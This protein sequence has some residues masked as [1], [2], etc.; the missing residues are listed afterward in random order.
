MFE[1]YTE[2]ARRVIFFSRYEASQYGSPYIEVAH[3]LLGLVREDFPTVS[4]V[5]AVEKAALQR[6]IEGLCVN[7]GQRVATTVDLPLAHPCRRVLSYAAEESGRLG[8]QHIGPEHLIMG[9][10]LE[11]GKEADVL[12][13]LGIGLDRAREV[14]RAPAA[15]ESAAKSE[16]VSHRQALARLLIQVPEDRLEAAVRILGCLSSGYFSASGTSSEGSFSYSFGS[17][18][19]AN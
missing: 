1:R 18:P 17:S 6:T 16:T 10:L 19:P 7:S 5:S 3:L 12:T 11:H 8:H 9:V 4:R 13:G 14:F 15:E 2:K